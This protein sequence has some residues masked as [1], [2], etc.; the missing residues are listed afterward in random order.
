M[1]KAVLAGITGLIIL[2]ALSAE[3]Y[4]SRYGKPAIHADALT[5][6]QFIRAA[7][8]RQTI[9][10]PPTTEN[11]PKFDGDQPFRSCK[12]DR[13]APAYHRP[14]KATI[15]RVIDGDT[16]AIMTQGAML[17]IRLWSIDAPEM[18]QTYGPAAREA[19]ENL[20]P[21]LSRVTI[22]PV[23]LD[24]HGRTVAVVDAGQKMPV[25]FTLVS[26]GHAFYRAYDQH[27]VCLKQAQ[28]LAEQHGLGVWGHWDEKPWEYR[29][30]TG[31][32]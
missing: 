3:L 27:S 25:N 15:N 22:Y 13:L 9:E 20:T 19:L 5:R 28:M 21:P 23:G 7:E 31:R 1:W 10:P 18:S 4:Q 6:D 29:R 32:Q 12:A 2:I 11:S 14:F 8:Q 26:R 30:R 16:L 24:L 17:R